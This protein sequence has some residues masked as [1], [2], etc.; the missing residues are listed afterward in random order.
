M[1]NI[2]II[3]HVIAGDLM[4]MHFFRYHFNFSRPFHITIMLLL[5]FSRFTKH[6]NTSHQCLALHHGIIINLIHLF[7][8]LYKGPPDNGR[9]IAG[10]WT[11]GL[12]ATGGRNNFVLSYDSSSQKPANTMVSKKRQDERLCE[13]YQL[14]EWI[15]SIEIA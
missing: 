13:G 11:V 5:I 14:P 7:I 4:I 10:R 15:Y 3:T 12:R 1:T 6:D 9:F 8:T 2:H